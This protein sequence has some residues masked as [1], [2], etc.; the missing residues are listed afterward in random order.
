M[1]LTE[2][3]LGAAGGGIRPASSAPGASLSCGGDP[4]QLWQQTCQLKL[5]FKHFI[6][7]YLIYNF[8]SYDNMKLSRYTRTCMSD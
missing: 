3:G 2:G 8:V 7:I 1:G 5:T 6:L 4:P